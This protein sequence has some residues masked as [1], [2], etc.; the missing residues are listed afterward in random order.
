MIQIEFNYY[1]T[2]FQEPESTIANVVNIDLD[3]SKRND[4]MDGQKDEFKQSSEFVLTTTPSSLVVPE[5]L[6]SIA[7]SRSSSTATQLFGLR[8]N[9]KIEVIN[10]RSLKN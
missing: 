9:K 5:V 4:D 3:S 10:P 2:Y 1:L 7:P 6:S 8:E